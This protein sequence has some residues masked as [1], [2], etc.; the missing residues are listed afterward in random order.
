MDMQYENHAQ[1]QK[2]AQRLEGMFEK[3]KNGEIYLW[4]NYIP[5]A[6]VSGLSSPYI[7]EYEDRSGIGKIYEQGAVTVCKCIC[8][9]MYREAARLLKM[10]KETKI[11]VYTPIYAYLDWEGLIREKL[12]EIDLKRLDA[13][14]FYLIY[15]SAENSQRV[16]AVYDFLRKHYFDDCQFGGQTGLQKYL[17]MPE[18]KECVQ[19]VQ[20]M[21]G[22]LKPVGVAEFMHLPEFLDS[23]ISFLKKRSENRD[24]IDR[25]LLDEMVQH[26]GT[27]KELL[28][29]Q[30]R[31]CFKE[32]P[33]LYWKAIRS[34]ELCS[35]YAGQIAVGK[36]A[37]KKLDVN[38]PVRSNIALWTARAV[39]RAK[40]DAL[41]E[42]CCV[43][44]L[45][46]NMTPWYY[47]L[48]TALSHEPEKLKDLAS[49]RLQKIRPVES[50][51]LDIV[52]ADRELLF[53][54]HLVA[55]FKF[56]LGDFYALFELYETKG[57]VEEMECGIALMLL[58][59]V[60]DREWKKGCRYL[61]GLLYWCAGPESCIYEYINAVQEE[62]AGS[63]K[64]DLYFQACLQKWKG[65]QQAL[66]EARTYLARLEALVF[67]RIKE[68]CNCWNA[69]YQEAVGL[70]VALGEVKESL[71]EKEGKRHVLSKCKAMIEALSEEL[72]NRHKKGFPRE[73]A[74]EI[75]FKH[76]GME[77]SI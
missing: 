31:I 65:R 41:A 16:Q 51:W 50:D 47:L 23:W 26:H 32:A 59:L 55:V 44:A 35:D 38:V 19:C 11:F 1:L 18:L 27:S 22:A 39:F 57:C 40:E 60:K 76:F 9:E 63:V 8:F 72:P 21:A 5:C 70:A 73:K 69:E 29:E 68:I 49:E 52:H 45:L 53:P 61:S 3:I 2:E 37:L 66:P 24:R 64:K 7:L 10:M 20:E 62:S 30:A 48:A 15:R 14:E 6:V 12:A 28:L 42:D 74:F 33:D 36:E 67:C 34:K 77:E 54:E 71:G 4:A 17:K 13:Y 46:S 58:L 56:F 43:Q 75:H 25:A